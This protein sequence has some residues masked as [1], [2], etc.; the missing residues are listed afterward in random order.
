MV[1]ESLKPHG[2]RVVLEGLKKTVVSEAF[3]RDL[4]PCGFRVVSEDLKPRGFRGVL[5]GSEMCGFRGVLKGS[6]NRP[7][8]QREFRLILKN[9]IGETLQ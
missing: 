8:F 2:F 6:K 7:W 5:E 1:S 4:K 9:P 3:Q